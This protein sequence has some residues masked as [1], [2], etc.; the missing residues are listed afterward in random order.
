MKCKQ[1]VV[2]LL[3]CM[4]TWVQ[5]SASLKPDVMIHTSAR[6]RVQ[7]QPVIETLS[8]KS[9]IKRTLIH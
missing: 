2:L 8:Q 7:D 3:A 1:R 6:E 9:N 5:S 4:K